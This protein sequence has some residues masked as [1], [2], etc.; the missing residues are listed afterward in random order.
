MNLAFKRIGIAE[1]LF[2]GGIALLHPLVVRAVKQVL[3]FGN[4]FRRPLTIQGIGLVGE[5]ARTK[6][7]RGAVLHGNL[8][9]GADQLRRVSLEVIGLA[10]RKG[11]CLTA[12]G[13]H[14]GIGSHGPCGR[15]EHR[16]RN[17]CTDRLSKGSNEG[18]DLHDDRNLYD[19]LAR[20]GSA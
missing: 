12:N 10:R 13:L 2:L 14:V 6:G 20:K 18:I 17:G 11:L 19:L 8:E 4:V 1:E 5:L 9:V 16:Y 7:E 15:K 3:E